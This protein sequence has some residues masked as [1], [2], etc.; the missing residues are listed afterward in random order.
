M[1]AISGAPNTDGSNIGRFFKFKL[2]IFCEYFISVWIE[3]PFQ[4]SISIM[5]RV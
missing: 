2:R 3:F 1:P 4:I 5:A